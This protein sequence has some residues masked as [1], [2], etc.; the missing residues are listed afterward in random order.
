MVR[1]MDES[2]VRGV[3]VALAVSGVA[4]VCSAGA[5]RRGVRV[6]CGV[7][8]LAAGVG[9]LVMAGLARP[10]VAVSQQYG[11]AERYRRYHGGR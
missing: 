4:G 7:V 1:E 9:G 11:A 6:L 10:V 2:L 8:S 5:R 3:G